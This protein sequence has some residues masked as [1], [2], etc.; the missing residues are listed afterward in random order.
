VLAALRAP[1]EARASV[2]G[3]RVQ[4]ARIEPG[5]MIRRHYPAAEL[6]RSIVLAHPECSDAA[7]EVLEREG[8]IASDLTGALLQAAGLRGTRDI[9]PA[10]ELGSHVLT[11]EEREQIS[12][13]LGP[14][15]I[16]DE[17]VDTILFDET[18]PVPLDLSALFDEIGMRGTERML[19]LMRIYARARERGNERVTVS[20]WTSVVKRLEVTP[21]SIRVLQRLAQAMGADP[22]E[23]EL[24]GRR[25]S[26]I[27][28]APVSRVL[29]LN[30]P[31]GDAGGYATQ[32]GFND[33]IWWDDV[34]R[35][36]VNAL[37]LDDTSIA[38]RGTYS[39]NDLDGA[40][41]THGRQRPSQDQLDLLRMAVRSSELGALSHLWRWSTARRPDPSRTYS[42]IISPHLAQL[43]RTQESVDLVRRLMQLEEVDERSVVLFDL[44]LSGHPPTRGLE[45][46]L[47]RLEPGP[48]MGEADVEEPALHFLV[49][50]KDPRAY[51]LSDRS[52][53]RLAK[54]EWDA[55]IMHQFFPP[56]VEQMT[57]LIKTLTR[58]VLLEIVDRPERVPRELKR[59]AEKFMPAPCKADAGYM[60]ALA[61]LCIAAHV[62]PDDIEIE[63]GLRLADHPLFAPA[64]RRLEHR[65]YAERAP[66]DRRNPARPPSSSERFDE[67][68]IAGLEEELLDVEAALKEHGTPEVFIAA[69]R[70]AERRAKDPENIVHAHRRIREYFRKPL[71]GGFVNEE[72]VPWIVRLARASSTPVEA[73]LVEQ[74]GEVVP[75]TS[76]PYF[77]DA[78]IPNRAH[79][80]ALLAKAAAAL[81][82]LA[83]SS[84]AD[85]LRVLTEVLAGSPAIELV[86][87]MPW[88]V[89]LAAAG[90]IAR[91]EGD[92]ERLAPMLGAFS[93]IG[94]LSVL[95]ALLTDLDRPAIAGLLAQRG[96]TAKNAE[97][98]SSIAV[99][100]R[101]LS[102]HEL[103]CAL[104]DVTRDPE[105]PDFTTLAFRM[106]IA[107]RADVERIRDQIDG[108]SRTP[109]VIVA[110]ALLE[111]AAA[112][113]ESVKEIVGAIDE[114][115][116]R[117][118]LL[119][120][121]VRAAARACLPALDLEHPEA[122]PLC[123][124]LAL[125]L[126][127]AL[128][129]HE[130]RP[131]VEGIRS[132]FD[133]LLPYVDLASAA[134]SVLRRAHE[135][136]LL[137]VAPLLDAEDRIPSDPGEAVLTRLVGLGTRFHD[138]AEDAL[139]ADDYDWIE[140]TVVRVD[141]SRFSPQAVV[142]LAAAF[143]RGCVGPT[144][145]AWARLNLAPE[146]IEAALPHIASAEARR[147]LRGRTKQ[148]T[149]HVAAPSSTESAGAA[150]IS[151][152]ARAPIRRLG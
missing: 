73:V 55:L 151:R 105:K 51:Q 7:A 96:H 126:A 36:N 98:W 104:R 78:M 1:L 141:P 61:E 95:A 52:L 18:S 116:A 77:R 54:Q 67:Q 107:M 119:E 38:R 60:E 34:A 118:T 24:Q 8:W 91:V 124:E 140:A 131:N 129:E 43:P 44:A 146:V 133:R 100:L 20:S 48:P 17:S 86:Q 81:D 6:A 27:H 113:P 127:D 59:Y 82:P 121:E 80:V 149:T 138:E 115:L 108:P 74:E 128:A 62:D 92:L 46:P 11:L 26:E 45:A 70:V 22:E 40:F 142:G 84:N 87:L 94:A 143:A 9:E 79:G 57:R 56:G 72:T 23:V 65:L 10:S 150:K 75:L 139:D 132:A 125:P 85:R 3:G 76:F 147:I 15:N 145:L 33:Y 31:V 135:G 66:I 53:E 64:L 35:G 97:R 21:E 69:A 122:W 13:G 134:R 30:A 130:A 123:A 41:F 90:R 110:R 137:R 49:T 71:P 12:H 93:H 102:G 58:A 50:D 68:K 112:S 63:D 42:P 16:A 19:G 111:R 152:G 109:P 99:D 37:R 117:G 101:A 47:P 14:R 89:S 29:E 4:V 114:S 136:D 25:L 144:I 88:L 28:R 83:R 103:A 32:L 2:L 120:A 39:E 106:A 5:S 148:P